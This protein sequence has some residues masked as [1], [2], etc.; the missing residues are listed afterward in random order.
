MARD[1]HLAPGLPGSGRHR[2]AAAMWFHARGEL[3][4]ETLE[5]FRVL[6]PRDGDDPAP[7]L[8]GHALPPPPEDAATR[9]T[10]IGDLLRGLMDLTGGIEGPGIAETRAAMGAVEGP[11]G[12][13]GRANPVVEAH[14]PAALAALAPEA[15]ALAASLRAAAPFL[16]WLTYAD[17]PEDEIGPAF[18]ASH[19]Y[20]SLLGETDAAWTVRG[21]DIGLFLMAPGLF[22]RDHAHPAP[23]LYL[24]L[25]G[26]H[27]W[28]R[29]PGAPLVDKPAF[30]PVWNDPDQPHA[31]LVGATPFLCLYAWL[32]L[33]QA[34]ARIVPADD[35][36]LHE[37]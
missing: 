10:A 5:V 22:Y 23:E 33:P 25:T 29:A 35:W 8:R 32:D 21:L 11:P 27:G 16:P 37:R 19:A 30:A 2:Y 3:A 28:R 12:G 34:A 13:R 24:P 14:L 18:A 1:L 17:Y 31:T 7:L 15:P 9:A 6:A 4:P 26:P 20:A 36:D